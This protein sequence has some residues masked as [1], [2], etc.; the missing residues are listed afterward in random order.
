[1][2]PL[3]KVANGILLLFVLTVLSPVA[4][5]NA[6]S[7]YVEPANL[8]ALVA[9]AAKEATLT[10]GASETF[11]GLAGA[12]LIQQHIEQK[13][14]IKYEIHYSPVGG[15]GAFLRQV[16]QEVRAGQTSSSDI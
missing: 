14:H 10:L 4:A 5:Q 16:A 1:M 6:P 9:A 15:G 7:T 8:T 11:G 3:M 2:L 12:Q 13:Y